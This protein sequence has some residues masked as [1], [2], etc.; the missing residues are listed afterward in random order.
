MTPPLRTKEDNEALQE[1][2]CNGEIQVVA[3]DHCAFT[4]EQKLRS[5]DTRTIYPG[6][7]GTEEILPLIYSLVAQ[8]ERLTVNEL[9][10]LLSTGPAKYFGL[11]PQK[12]VLRE[13]SDADIVI[14][15]PDYLWTLSRETTH[16][17]SLYTPY[18]GINVQGKA[19]M[20]YLRGRLIMGDNMYL[21]IDGDGRFVKATR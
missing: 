20:T 14:F 10:N 4:Y 6:I 5:S 3:S 17:A 16:S 11:Y 18:E 2:L 15:N 7:P 19:V 8:G 12:G 21:G 1:A 9:V 13:G